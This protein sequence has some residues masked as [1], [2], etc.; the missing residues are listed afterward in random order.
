MMTVNWVTIYN[1]L[2][3]LIDRQGAS[4]YSGPRFI[5]KVREVD[6]YFANYSQYLETRRTGCKSTSRR[7][8]F[9]DILLELPV[10]ARMRVISSILDG[11][12][13][14]DPNLVSEVRSL[15][16]GSAQAPAAIVPPFAWG[17]DRL[18]R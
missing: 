17:A 3:S 6:P 5:G 16:V 1:R 2:F 9:Y 4:Y 13:S 12:E 14:V 8:Y 7:D 11:V 15:M 18:N 10:G